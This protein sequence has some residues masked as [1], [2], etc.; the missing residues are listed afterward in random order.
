MAIASAGDI[1]GIMNAA[2]AIGATITGVQ[3]SYEKAGEI[4]PSDDA[5]DLPAI[6]Q[7]VTGADLPA[8]RIGPDGIDRQVFHHYWY[9]DLLVK[10]SG[11]IYAEQD[12]AMPF[13]PLVVEKFNANRHLGNR[14]IVDYCLVENYRFV[15]L[16]AGETQFFTIR[17][18]M[19]ARTSG[20]VTF[21]DPS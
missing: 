10:R 18:L 19:H 7:S 16:S 2:A 11:D 3:T 5:D 6:L 8:G 14:I 20:A 13:V 12:A 21:T 9:F 15:I 4:P 1:K 17:F